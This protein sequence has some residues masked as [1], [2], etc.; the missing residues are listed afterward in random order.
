MKR[1][2][3]RIRK[4]GYRVTAFVAALLMFL[5]G[6]DSNAYAGALSGTSV[7]GK[8]AYIFEVVTGVH[9][10]EN[11]QFLEI[12]YIG[13]D[14]NEYRQLFFPNQDSQ[15]LG[16]IQA[17]KA[18]SD[19]PI[20][21]DIEKMYGYKGKS[22]RF[23]TSVSSLASYSMA[24]YYFTTDVPIKS[25]RTLTVSQEWEMMNGHVRA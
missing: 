6:L 21:N 24:Q 10:G 15:Y 25:I 2:L 4:I 14:N 1:L 9:D 23:D 8:N 22:G 17:E 11:I 3:N 20:A 16:R 19:A 18:G 12:V 5:T 13:T 7:T